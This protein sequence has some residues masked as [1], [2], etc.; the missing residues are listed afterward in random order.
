MQDN[1]E[2]QACLS[3]DIGS[4]YVK[5][6]IGRRSENHTIEI[7]GVGSA[8]Q[9]VYSM[10]Q[11]SI[12]DIESVIET[13]E[14]AI[15]LAENQAG[16]LCKTVSIGISGS[17]IKSDITQVKYIRKNSNKNITEQELSKIFNKIQQ[18]SKVKAQQEVSLELDN[19]RVEVGLVNSALLSLSI[20]GHKV[21]DPV[22]FK[23][24]EISMQFY[25]AFAP[26]V[27][28]S[29]LEK[30]CAE[31]NLEIIS[32]VAEPFATCRA[33]ISDHPDKSADLIILDIGGGHT[34]LS[35]AENG[36]IV[37]ME[38]INIGGG[39]FSQKNESVAAWLAALQMS[40]E[41]VELEALPERIFICGGGADNIDLQESLA[42]SDWYKV[43][44]FKRRPIIELVGVQNIPDAINRSDIEL[45]HSH[46]TAFGI[47]KVGL[48][49][50]IDGSR[51]IGLK[52]KISRILQN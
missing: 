40:L 30:I 33:C 19:E 35:V 41:E 45:N 7:L 50:F 5:A 28:I 26:V 11:G 51:K 31:L 10:E 23:G 22:G 48:D 3:L 6:V 20:D 18:K 2:S 14:K 47:L 12:V 32:L 25:T 24:S 34:N 39:N 13:C 42:L 43:L 17:V 36:N 4:E 38:S 52:E 21:N 15:Q 49:V 27:A 8:K 1:S 46:I 29:A 37:Y 16:V 44:P 9:K